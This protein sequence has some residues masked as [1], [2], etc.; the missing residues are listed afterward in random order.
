MV[1]LHINLKGMKHAATNTV[2]NTFINRL[3]PPTSNKNQTCLEHGH[4]SYQIKKNWECSNMQAQLIL[5]LSPSPTEPAT[6]LPPS[7]G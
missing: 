3:H 5:F 4:F 1:M 7:H 6:L 2:P